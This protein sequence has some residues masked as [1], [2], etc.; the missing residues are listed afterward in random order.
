MNGGSRPVSRLGALIGVLA[1]LLSLAAVAA[2]AETLRHPHPE[3]EMRPAE[4]GADPRDEVVCPRPLPRE[5]ESRLGV[6]GRDPEL[7]AVSSDDLY[8]CP[9]FFDQ[10]VVSFQGEVVGGVM[11]RDEGAWVQLND[12]AYAGLLGP[13]PAHRDLRGGNSGIGVLVPHD[14]A[15]GI[16]VV[17]GPAT[18]G[19][20]LSVMGVF[21]RVDPGTRE[22]A[23]IRATTVEVLRSGTEV[24]QPRLPEREVVGWLLAAL[25][26][27]AVAGE[28]IALRRHRRGYR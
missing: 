5:G 17:G 21:Y 1:V 18:R 7:T 15:E 20:L 28:R 27:L 25:A 10:Q 2:L 11:R 14:V 24:E 4:P 12:D 3:A 22:V 23:V 6:V 9:E 8:D 19:D 16:E 13:L 26:A